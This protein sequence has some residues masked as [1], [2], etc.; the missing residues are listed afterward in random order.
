MASMAYIYCSERGSRIEDVN[1][2]VQLRKSA[3]GIFLAYII[4]I[5][6]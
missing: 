3:S 5:I 1:P 2:G 6:S 4:I